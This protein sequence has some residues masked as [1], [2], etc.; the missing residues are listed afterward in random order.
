MLGEPDRSPAPSDEAA[1]PFAGEAAAL[2]DGDA[3]VDAAGVPVFFR[4][5]LLRGLTNTGLNLR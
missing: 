1:S 5:D 4:G 2:F 3:A